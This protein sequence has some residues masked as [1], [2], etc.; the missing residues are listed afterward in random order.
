MT[1]DSPAARRQVGLSLLEL[2]VA[3][4]VGL[5]AIAGILYIYKSQQ[6]SML[7]QTGLADLRLNGQFTLNEVQHYL[8]HAGMGLP[9]SLEDILIIGGDL[10]VRIN[11]SKQSASAQKHGSGGGARTLYRVAAADADLFRKAPF[12]VALS[13]NQALEAEI[14]DVTAGPSAGEALVV[15]RGNPSGFPA[16]AQLYPLERLRLH[17]CSGRGADTLA[18]DFRVLSTPAPGGREIALDTLTLAEGI[19]S[20][21]YSYFLAGRRDSLTSLPADLDSLRSI[22]VQVVART[23]RKDQALPGDGYRRQILVAKVNYR[24][25]L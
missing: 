24:R 15:L 7:A 18:G 5:L 9:G 17:V 4:F 13:G 1:A 22:R 8:T 20:L 10:A 3:S 12:A 6:K 21:S 19:E 2:L 16:G 23:L 14:L 11:R 25:S